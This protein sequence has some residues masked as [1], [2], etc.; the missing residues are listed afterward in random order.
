MG[1]LLRNFG[2]QFKTFSKWFLVAGWLN[3]FL[4][5][6]KINTELNTEFYI[7]IIKIMN[8]WKKRRN[9][10]KYRLGAYFIPDLQHIL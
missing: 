7:R 8:E 6:K 3:S 4:F 1:K 9:R 5:V 10:G 2:E